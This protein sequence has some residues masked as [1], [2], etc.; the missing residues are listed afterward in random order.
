MRNINRIQRIMYKLQQCW[1]AFPDLRFNQ[2]IS[3]INHEISNKDDFD[4]YNI[5]DERFEL[6]LDKFMLRQKIITVILN[7]K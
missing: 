3:N 1:A 2:L 5:E 7:E 6:A 4:Y